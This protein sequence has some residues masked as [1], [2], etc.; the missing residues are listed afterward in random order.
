MLEVFYLYVAYVCNTSVL[1]CFCK[2]FRHMFQV[3]YLSFFMLQVLHLNVLKVDWV[4]AHK[5]Y[6][7]SRRECGTPA[8]PHETQTRAD[9]WMRENGLQLR[10]SGCDCPWTSAC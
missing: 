7:G 3:F 9:A 4:F 8:W 10:A 5:M 6:V 2:C 1:K